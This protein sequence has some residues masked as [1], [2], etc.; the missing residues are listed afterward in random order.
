MRILIT[1]CN[2]FI[3]YHLCNRLMSDGFDITG[4]DNM[5]DYYDVGLKRHRLMNL[6][7]KKNKLIFYKVDINDIESL[8][9]IFR[10]HRFD[11]VVHLAAQA[12]VRY[13]LENPRAYMDTN[14]NGFFNILECC[15]EFNV[16]RLL[17]A[18]SSSVYGNS[19]SYTDEPVSLY[20]ATKKT[21]ELLAYTY[22]RLY[23]IK[24]IGMRFFT[25]YGE[26][27]RPDMAYWKFTEKIMNNESIHI[28]NFGDIYRDFTYV[29]D[30]IEGVCKILYADTHFKYKVYDIGSGKS[31]S[32]IRFVKELH[33]QMIT[34]GLTTNELEYKY[35]PMQAGDVYFTCAHLQ[36]MKNDYDFKPQTDIETGLGKFV[37][38]FSMFSRKNSTFVC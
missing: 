16:D 37:E 28:Y 20:A 38:W 35:E 19:G 22:S 18:S 11:T 15:R 26:Y 30:I 1:G 13:S 5:N 25:V 24:T 7:C 2:G 21:N 3:G 4:I 27:G 12:G 31:T 33:R 9:T 6:F 34:H 32:V 36:E 29:G 17:F 10:V 8:R 14:V 23:G